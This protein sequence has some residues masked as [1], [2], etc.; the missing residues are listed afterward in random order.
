MKMI[1]PRQVYVHAALILANSLFALGSI[2]GALGLSTMNPLSFTLIREIVAGILLLLLSLIFKAAIGRQVSQQQQH[3]SETEPFLV[4]TTIEDYNYY[5]ILKHGRGHYKEEYQQN[6]YLILPQNWKDWKSFML[7]GF[8]VSTDLG[9]CICG[10]HLAGPV[11][12]SIWQPSRTIL[13]AAI[14]MVLR[15]E[16]VNKWRI[17]GV[18][19]A[20]IGCVSI[21]LMNNNDHGREDADDQHVLQ[22]VQHSSLLFL[23]GN[24]LFF[25][26]CLCDSVLVLWSKELLKVYPPL[27]VAAW[28]YIFACP[29]M[30]VGLVTSSMVLSWQAV[31][32]TDCQPWDGSLLSL[33]SIPKDALPALLYYILAMSMSAW[34][35]ILWANQY[36]TGTFVVGY[37][38]LQPVMSLVFVVLLLI[39]G[40]VSDCQEPLPQMGNSTNEGQMC[41]DKPGFGALVGMLGIFVGLALVTQTEPMEDHEQTR[42]NPQWTGLKILS[43]EADFTENHNRIYGSM[44]SNGNENLL[45]P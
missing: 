42:R 37:S 16:K 17:L 6:Y 28:C 1:L 21:V 43:L 34:G 33:F 30:L 32:C 39:M 26:A 22:E 14:S 35:L 45:R 27:T 25:L 2:V 15:L 38:V 41:L 31:I 8:L 19:V 44:V 23:L 18:L 4:A 3:T 5:R 24:C 13:T 12:A 11:V 20:F 29:F 7:F 9:A 40:G 36:V 10:L